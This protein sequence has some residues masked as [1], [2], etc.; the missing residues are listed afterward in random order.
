MKVICRCCHLP[1]DYDMYM[2]LCPKCGRVYRRGREHYSAVE[3]D[4][5]GTFHLEG[6]EGG[7]NRGISGVVY[8]HSSQ[9]GIK[10]KLNGFDEDFITDYNEPH[11]AGYSQYV[12]PAGGQAKPYAKPVAPA[13]GTVNP[14]AKPVQSLITPTNTAKTEKNF[15]GNGY[16]SP[17]HKTKMNQSVG[18]NKKG[19]DAI[20]II[21]FIFIIAAFIAGMFD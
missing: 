11:S 15:S 2:G 9:D 10:T 3:R 18:K 21:I 8:N 16:Y 14:V 6:D 20:G 17:T 7:L 4:M 12:K 13:T 19:S 1:F 5:M